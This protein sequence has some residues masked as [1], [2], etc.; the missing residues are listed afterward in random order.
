MRQK[1]LVLSKQCRFWW[2]LRHKDVPDSRVEVDSLDRPWFRFANSTW[3]SLVAD[4]LGMDQHSHFG[5]RKRTLFAGLN[6]PE[7]HDISFR[8]NEFL[9][10]DAGGHARSVPLRRSPSGRVSHATSR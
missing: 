2:M 7:N 4:V 3:Q 1:Q 8:R 10:Y 6:L 9:V 5:S